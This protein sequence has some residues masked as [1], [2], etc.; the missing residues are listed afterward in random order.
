LGEFDIGEDAAI[1]RLSVALYIGMIA[2]LC[3]AV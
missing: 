1:P 3:L 2:A